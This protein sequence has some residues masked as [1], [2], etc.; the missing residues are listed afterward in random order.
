MTTRPRQIARIVTRGIIF[1]SLLALLA[2]CKKA[3]ASDPMEGRTLFQNNCARCH[4]TE[5]KGGL[6]VFE[7]GPS[8]RN[9]SEHKFQNERSDEQLRMTIVNGKGA[10]M[11]PFGQAFND[12]QLT[13][14]VAHVRSLDSESKK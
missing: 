14:L 9:F 11:P 10:G 7:G 13:A 6:P 4:G 12:A 5:G 8:P 1:V 2:G 3:E